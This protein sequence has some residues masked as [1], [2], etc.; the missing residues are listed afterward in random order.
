MPRHAFLPI[1]AIAGVLIFAAPH[2]RA[3]GADRFEVLRDQA[4]VQRAGKPLLADVYRPRQAGPFPAVLLIHGGAWA[5]G[6]KKQLGWIAEPLADRGFTVVA[7]D[8]RLAPG[9][10]FPAQID[11]CRA[12]LDWMIQHAGPMK[13]DPGRIG[14]W[15]YSAG[16]QLAALLGVTQ[17]DMAPANAGSPAK[18]A[19]PAPEASGNGQ[20]AKVRAVV[21][22][23][24]PCDFSQVPPNNLALSFWLGGTRAGK[25]DVYRSAS[26]AL[27]VSAGCPPMFFYHGQQDQ[28]VPLAQ[29]TDMARRL[30]AAGVPHDLYVVR[31]AGHRGAMF[32]RPAMEKGIA[33]LT[34]YLKP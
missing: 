32:D 3:A 22:G 16:G 12:A 5:A 14:V 15:G 7:I 2:A 29:A 6:T 20:R 10:M 33:F 4:Y 17:A 34:K 21:A 26:P 28:L 9:A 18:Q 23:G 31:G 30:E 1:V 24:A 13:I 11:D 27:Q 19:G 25:P 8:Y